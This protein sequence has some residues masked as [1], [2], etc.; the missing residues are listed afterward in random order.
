MT[1]HGFESVFMSDLDIFTCNWVLSYCIDNT[2]GRCIN[3]FSQP[4]RKINA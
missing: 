2:I 3:F 1:V 4:T